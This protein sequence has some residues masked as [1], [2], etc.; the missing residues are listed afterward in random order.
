MVIRN[1]F[2]ETYDNF[3][4]TYDNFSRLTIIWEDSL[5]ILLKTIALGRPMSN[6][7]KKPGDLPGLCILY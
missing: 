6:K 1:S 5:Q 3:E 2:F 7:T 4:G